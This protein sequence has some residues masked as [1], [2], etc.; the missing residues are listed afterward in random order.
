MVISADARAVYSIQA[1]CFTR[2]SSIEA[3]IDE[4][5]KLEVEA[6]ICEN[7]HKIQQLYQEAIVQLKHTLKHE[8][9]N[10]RCDIA[11]LKTTIE[12]SKADAAREKDA[13]ASVRRE[14]EEARTDAAREK[15]CV[16]ICSTRSRGGARRAGTGAY[17]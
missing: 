10:A 9:I 1:L 2:A 14:L 13:S 5:F 11:R 17:L 3:L 8:T 7:G 15:R 12:L 6:A 16:G 4:T